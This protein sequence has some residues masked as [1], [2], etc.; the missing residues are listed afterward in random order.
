[1]ISALK[2]VWAY[3]W[4]RWL[5]SFVFLYAGASKLIDPKAF[6]ALIDAY[7]IV[8][9][10]LLMPVAIGLPLIEVLAAVSLM[11]DV[12]GSLAVISGLMAVFIAIMVYGIMM[13]IDV[14]CGCFGPEDIESRAYHGLREALYRDLVMA[15]GI[16]YLYGW[17]RYRPAPRSNYP[18]QFTTY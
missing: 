15:G 12:R 9:D 5:L 11:A 3:R 14:D 2:S 7:G 4:I 16:F 8:P 6:A 17:R 1:V 13:G 18:R 10:P